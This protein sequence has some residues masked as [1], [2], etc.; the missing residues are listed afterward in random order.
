MLS[1]WKGI[2]HHHEIGFSAN[3]VHAKALIIIF[4]P[5]P[6]FFFLFFNLI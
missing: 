6:P 5:D 1:F 4:F 2:L 3:Q